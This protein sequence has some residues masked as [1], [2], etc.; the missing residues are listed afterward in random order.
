ML[1]KSKKGNMLEIILGGIPINEL[2]ADTNEWF[3]VTNEL[4]E[5]ADAL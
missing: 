4:L 5:Q 1:R 3:T 2:L